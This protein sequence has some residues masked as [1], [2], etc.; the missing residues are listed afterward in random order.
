VVLVV[1]VSQQFRFKPDSERLSTCTTTTLFWI[2][3][4][5]D[6]EGVPPYSKSTSHE[7]LYA[8]PS[9]DPSC[10]YQNQRKNQI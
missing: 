5:E 3:Y 9:A 6:S 4:I 7:L 8:W 10:N 2:D 1:A